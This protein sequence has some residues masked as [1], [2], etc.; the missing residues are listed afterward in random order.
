MDFFLHSLSLLLLS[1]LSLWTI[2]LSLT[3]SQPCIALDKKLTD[4]QVLPPNVVIPKD[5]CLIESG[6]YLE[7]LV[8]LSH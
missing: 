7:Y 4:G 8:G 2:C 1:K 6:E 3:T 5:F